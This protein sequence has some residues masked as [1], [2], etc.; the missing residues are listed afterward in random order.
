M[1]RGDQGLRRFGPPMLR[2]RMLRAI[3]ERGICL[4]AGKEPGVPLS[5]YWLAARVGLFLCSLPLRVR[6]QALP[7]M[8]QRL[9]SATGRPIAGRAMEP[10]RVVQIVRRVCRL[11]VFGLPV[12]PKLC[13]RQSLALFRFLSRMGYPVEIHFGVQK[14]GRN[15]GGHSWVVLHGRT[16]GERSPAEEFR[17]I[18]SHAAA[19]ERSGLPGI[20]EPQL[21]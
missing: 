13:L 2:P 16:L 7:L 17:T 11:G 12:F 20:G 10:G 5:Q 4:T 19:S 8:L 18:Y 21:T 6:R 3:V 15:L 1:F 14:D 9:T